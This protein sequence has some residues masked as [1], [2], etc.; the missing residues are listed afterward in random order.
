M[1]NKKAPSELSYTTRGNGQKTFPSG[2]NLCTFYG[3]YSTRKYSENG[4][5]RH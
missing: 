2:R 5:N 1:N 3:K 4:Y